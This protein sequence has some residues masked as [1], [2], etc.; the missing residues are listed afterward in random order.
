[1]SWKKLTDFPDNKVIKPS[2]GSTIAYW[3]IENGKI[4]HQWKKLMKA[5][6]E[7]FEIYESS[8]F[9]ARDKDF[10]YHAWTKLSKVDRDTFREVGD[11]YWKD[12]NYAYL[13]Y[14][15]SIKPLKRLDVSSFNYLGSGYAYD[16]SFAYFYGKVIKSCKH[17]TTLKT[18]KK[19]TNF[20]RNIEN[21]F[22]EN[23]VL[24]NA[25]VKTW[26]LLK[27]AFSRDDKRIYFTA[28]KLPK[29]DIETW[30]H[31]HR[32]FSKDKNNVYCVEQIQEDKSPNDWGK[33]KVME[34]YKK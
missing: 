34:Q 33:E 9:V 20:A 7:S 3:K 15:T 4:W 29:V 23:A 24:K 26:K 22:Y 10:V 25:D 19:N 30:E 2:Y 17:P 1:M 31:I 32:A 8:H 14:E 28:R 18:I 27:N 13:K 16:K 6:I 21:I 5:D 12:K 11:S